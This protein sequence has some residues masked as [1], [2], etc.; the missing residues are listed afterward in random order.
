LLKRIV[1]TIDKFGLKCRHL[2]K[3]VL[4]TD[5]FFEKYLTT[6][7]K[8]ELTNKYVKRLKKNWNELW[9]FYIMMLFRGIIT[10]PK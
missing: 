8:S 10:T 9:T 5:K 7:Y 6:E 4:E 1:T 2:K 3:H